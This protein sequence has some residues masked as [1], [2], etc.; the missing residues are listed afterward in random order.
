MIDT[1]QHKEIEFA[2]FVGIDWAD[3]KHAW[4]LQIPGHLEVERGDLDHTPQAVED[5]AAEL[6]RRFRGFAKR[7]VKSGSEFCGIG[8]D[9][10][11]GETLLV[12]LLANGTHAAIHHITRRDDVRAGLNVTCSGAR[13][14]LKRRI[15][16]DLR[17]RFGLLHDTAMAVFHVFAQAD[18]GKDQQLRKLPFQ[19]ANG[20]LHDAIGSVG[21]RGAIIFGVRNTEQQ[22]SGHS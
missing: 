22:Y 10:S 18:I 21:T 7:P 14:Q 9:R 4:A 5:W 13:Q 20:A 16:K 1:N 17:A 6:G 19:Q 15:I 11:V 3:L 2:A 12:Q 8:H